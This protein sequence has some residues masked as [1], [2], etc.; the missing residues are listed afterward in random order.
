MDNLNLYA[1]SQRV[2]DSLIQTMKSFSDDVGM[3]FGLDKCVVLVLERAK[4]IQTEEIELTDGKRMR[5]VNLDGYKYLGVLE[6]E[7]IMNRE[8]KEKVKSEYIRRI[9]K[10]LRSQLNKANVIAGMNAWAG[11]II[12]YGAGVLE[13]AK[14]DL[15]SIDIKARKLMTMGGSQNPRENVGRFYLARKEVGRG[16]ISCEECVN[17]EVQNLH[18]YLNESEEWML[19]FVAGKKGLPEVEDPDAFKKRLKEKKGSH[20]LEKSLYDRFLKDAKKVSIER[21]R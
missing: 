9:K 19:K 13:R 6:L 4:M 12:R 20:W 11:V 16:L 14:E 2:L 3:A 1:K 5:E 15:K 8:M 7:S 18:K 21:T 10:L 17:M